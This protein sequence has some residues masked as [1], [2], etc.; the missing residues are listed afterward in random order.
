MV[1]DDSIPGD[2]RQIRFIRLNRV[3]VTLFPTYLQFGHGSPAID[4]RFGKR[5]A[6]DPPNDI[7]SYYEPALA[8]N[9]DGTLVIACSRTGS[10]IWPQARYSVYFEKDSDIRPSQLLRKGEYPIGIEDPASGQPAD[11]RPAAG[12]FDYNAAAV[13]PLDDRSVWTINVY[14][15]KNNVGAGQYSLLVS[16]IPFNSGP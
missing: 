11:N 14:A 12:I 9:K 4:R 6:A 15:T 7:F 1:W 13:D 10:T 2:A 8:V 5:N 16:R 3:D